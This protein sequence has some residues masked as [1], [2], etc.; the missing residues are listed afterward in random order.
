M[1]DKL[2]F[3]KAADIESEMKRIE[4]RMAHTT[5]TLDEEKRLVSQLASLNK[6]RDVVKSFGTRQEQ[7]SLDEE[8]RKGIIDKIKAQD[9]ILN[10]IKAREGVLQQQMQVAKTKE[11]SVTGDVPA[12]IAEREA[13]IAT[14]KEIRGE[15][16]TLR[17]GFRELENAYY[18]QQRELR[19]VIKKEREERRL[20]WIE[21]KKQ[22][23]ADRKRRDME[24]APPPYHLEITICEQLTG[25]L[26]K[27]LPSEAAA[28]ADDAAAASTSAESSGLVLKQRTEDEEGMDK[29]FSGTSKKG[30]RKKKKGGKKNDPAA[31]TD[32]TKLPHSIET[33]TSFTTIGVAVPI[34][35]ADIKPALESIEV[36]AK[37]YAELSKEGQ[38]KREEALAAMIAAA[39][40]EAAAE[41]N[42]NGAAADAEKKDAEDGAEG[43]EEEAKG[44]EGDEK[45]EEPAA[46]AEMAEA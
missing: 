45:K 12:L 3:V 13:C 10:E 23:D 35:V 34:T 37:E 24:N 46:D 6:S 26:S 17:D 27:F 31:M 30:G 38:K 44:E 20:Q 5:L 7:L 9:T 22:R 4:E 14:I 29:M 42:G 36:K 25:Y 2:N 40:N 33:Y 19:D 8:A 32:K 21:E 11:D 43:E 1:K 15:I 41:S 28:P 39:E 18:S 16:R